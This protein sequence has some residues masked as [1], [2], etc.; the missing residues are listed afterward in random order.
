MLF[1]G[2][3]PIIR[4][5]NPAPDT[6]VAGLSTG[7]H[8]QGTAKTTPDLRTDAAFAT[9]RKHDRAAPFKRSDSFFKPLNTLTFHPASHVINLSES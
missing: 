1:L 9:I 2:H 6:L 8:L 5:A 4:L 3:A 7:V